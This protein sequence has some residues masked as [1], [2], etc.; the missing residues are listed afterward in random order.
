MHLFNKENFL[1]AAE[2]SDTIKDLLLAL[3]LKLH[4]NNYKAV[5]RYAN[6]ENID[7]NRWLKGR[8]PN[9]KKSF[10]EVLVDGNLKLNPRIKKRLIKE[11]LKEEC[12][13]CGQGPVWN[14]E[15]LTLQI[16]HING[17]NTDNRIVNLRVLC[18]NCHTQT[19]THGSKNIRRRVVGIPC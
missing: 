8:V 12:V 19:P 7:L 16:D 14:G 17:R 4:G 3:G 9:N 13:K 2:Q 15:P 6:R 10:D 18:P 11:L 1:T 5:N